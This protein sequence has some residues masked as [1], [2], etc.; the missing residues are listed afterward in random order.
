MTDSR[1]KLYYS[2]GA[3]S[4]SPHIA[5]VEAGLPHTLARVDLKT[6]KLANGDDFLAVNTKGYVPVLELG[7][8]LRLTEGPAI[9]QYVA[10][11]APESGLAPA[12]GTMERHR[13]QEWLNFITAEVHKPWG[14][15]FNPQAA[16]TLVLW[17]RDLLSRRLEWTAKQLAGKPYL[18]GERF[19]VADAY[20]F[21]ILNWSNYT[22]LDLSTW[23]VLGDYVERVAARP[24][25]AEAMRAE[26][27]VRKPKA[28]AAD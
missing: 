7:N 13:L 27:L 6:R 12:H 25:V 10:D 5:L 24:A 21:T 20:L 11:Q 2:P 8:G 18:M 23:P 22:T 15:L 14:P 4:L 1:I 9:V 3:C 26:G 16:P 17:S 19:T 28:L